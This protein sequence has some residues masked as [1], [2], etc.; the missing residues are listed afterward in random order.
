MNILEKNI[1]EFKLEGDSASS[2]FENFNK[3]FVYLNCLRYLTTV[4]GT[5]FK[6]FKT[7]AMKMD[8]RLLVFVITWIL[9]IIN[10]RKS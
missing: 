9:T 2:R 6:H 7:G 3:N 1:L 10:R 5:T 4:Q 8:E